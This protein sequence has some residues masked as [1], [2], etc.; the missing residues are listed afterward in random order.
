MARALEDW[1]EAAAAGDREGFTAMMVEARQAV[2]RAE[3]R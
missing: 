1:L 2:G 3:D